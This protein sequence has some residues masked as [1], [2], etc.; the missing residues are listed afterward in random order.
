MT[1][2][3]RSMWPDRPGSTQ[4]SGISSAAA[5]PGH[6]PLPGYPVPADWRSRVRARLIDQAPTYVGLI[7]FLAGYLVWVIE[8]A[9]S[10]GSIPDFEGA[11]VAMIIG[12]SVII[13]SLAWVAYNRWMVAGRTG[14]SLGKRLT[15]IRLIGEETKAPV[16]ALNAFV[17]D[18]VHIL[19][20]LT[21]VGYL[22][23]RWD[24]RKQTFGDKIMKTIV[25]N[26]EPPN[27]STRLVTGRN[28]H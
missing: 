5:E 18:L 26:A 17:R 23:P 8:L 22:W 4:H 21:I 27:S 6:P 19:D 1:D 25:I 15:K 14:Q 16:G 2:Q 10:G 28:V 12:L 13:A 3:Y 11:V 20:G 9:Q 24:D 7:I